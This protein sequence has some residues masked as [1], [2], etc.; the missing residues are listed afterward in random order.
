MNA[1]GIGWF[2]VDVDLQLGHCFAQLAIDVLP[3]PDT[4]IVQKFCLAHPSKVTF[5]AVALL[6]ADVLPQL[7]KSQEIGSLNSKARM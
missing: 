3:L 4:E 2:V 5:G 7:H 6:L 1:F